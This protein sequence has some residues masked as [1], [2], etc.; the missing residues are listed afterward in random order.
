MERRF[1]HI[2]FACRMAASLTPV[3]VEGLQK[4]IPVHVPSD[5]L[6]GDIIEKT[7]ALEKLEVGGFECVL[8]ER[9]ACGG[10]E[11]HGAG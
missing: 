5:Y 7:I 10:W 4:A 3:W 9:Y 2:D 6:V 8:L 1:I 11:R